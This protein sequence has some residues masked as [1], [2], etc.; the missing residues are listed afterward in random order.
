MMNTMPCAELKKLRS[1]FLIVI[2][3]SKSVNRND[4][5]YEKSIL[6]N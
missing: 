6:K 1:K 4:K 3:S 5:I 2:A